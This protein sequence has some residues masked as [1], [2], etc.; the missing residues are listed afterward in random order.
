MGLRGRSRGGY[1][2]EQFGIRGGHKG[3]VTGYTKW[4]Q[5]L[6]IRDGYK[7]WVL[8]VE[9]RAGCREGYKGGCR[10]GY[11]GRYKGWV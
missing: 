11:R 8:G 7:G 6:G 10:E 5:G 4:I 2:D 1:R 3:W 9:L